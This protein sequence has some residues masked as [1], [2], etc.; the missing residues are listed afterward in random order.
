MTFEPPSDIAA[1][2]ERLLDPTHEEHEEIIRYLQDHP[3]PA[4]AP[5]LKNAIALKPALAYL[6]Y[7]D[8]GAYYKKCL[9][10]LQAIGTAEPIAVIRECAS[11]DDEALR[12]QALYRLERIAQKARSACLPQTPH[13]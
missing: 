1:E 11:A 13:R 5:C 12:M 6:D 4:S 2:R 8:Y 10:A 9:W 7:D 3:D